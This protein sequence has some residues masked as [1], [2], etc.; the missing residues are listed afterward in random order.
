M[1]SGRVL[2]GYRALLEGESVFLLRPLIWRPSAHRERVNV[3]QFFRDTPIYMSLSVQQLHPFK[4]GRDN[5]NRELCP[6]LMRL[7]HRP[8]PKPVSP[9]RQ[10]YYVGW[11]CLTTSSAGTR[12]F[13]MRTSSSSV[14]GMRGNGGNAALLE[15]F[16][17]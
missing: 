17:K 16:F 14:R 10:E 11:E 1:D 9:R 7:I 8:L 13:R 12:S 6:A 5:D 2:G 4:H 15:F 3:I